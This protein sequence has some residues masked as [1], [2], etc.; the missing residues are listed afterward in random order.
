MGLRDIFFQDDHHVI[1]HTFSFKMITMYILFLTGLTPTNHCLRPRMT[2]EKRVRKFSVVAT[3]GTLRNTLVGARIF[4]VGCPIGHMA[5]FP[6]PYLCPMLEIC[7][8]QTTTKKGKS[9]K[10]NRIKIKM[11]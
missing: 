9:N 4:I 6:L 10:I 11:V 1:L 8:P 3:K 2:S 5:A 7:W